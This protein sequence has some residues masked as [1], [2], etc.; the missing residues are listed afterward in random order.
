MA[1]LE[2][3]DRLKAAALVNVNR[4]RA[5]SHAIFFGVVFRMKGFDGAAAAVSA[6]AAAATTT[7]PSAAAATVSSG[8]FALKE[9]LFEYLSKT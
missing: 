9:L 8:T 7:S 2:C 1:L 3:D 4:I 5:R 6:A